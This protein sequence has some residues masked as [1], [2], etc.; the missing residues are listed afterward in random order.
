MPPRRKALYFLACLAVV[1]IW[2]GSFIFIRIGLRDFPP[3]TLALFRFALAFL[4]LLL[5]RLLTENRARAQLPFR[6]G[7][8]KLTALALTGVTFL[9]ILQFYSLELISAS[10]GATVINTTVIFMALLSA[11][12]LN[13]RLTFKKVLG[14]LIAFFGVSMLLLKGGGVN[15]P[16]SQ[17]L[18]GSLMIG[19]AVCWAVY[20]V[21]TKKVLRDY[22]NVTMMT[23]T[24]GLG[25]LYLIPFALIED[26]LKAA[27][28]AS[29]IGWISILYL[30]ILSSALA[31]FLWNEAIS[32][33][34]V[35]KVGAFLYAIPI[36]T[37]ILGH[38]FLGEEITPSLIVGALL[39]IFG[40]YLTEAS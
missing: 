13:E 36:P 10:V 32:K 21:L 39:V 9:Y 29:V 11:A 6:K 3:A 23:V 31:Y 22:S 19:A 4:C 12:F 40:V 16:P 35:A 33:L 25:A 30:A 34:E 1:L 26:P 18:G 37:I 14:I 15:S 5:A 20:S 38:L 27:V 7:F 17:L 24:F 8:V 2:S 28:K